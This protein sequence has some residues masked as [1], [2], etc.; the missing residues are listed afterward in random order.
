M[1]VKL[2]FERDAVQAENRFGSTEKSKATGFGVESMVYE[3]LKC[4]ESFA[5][6]DH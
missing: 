1:L 3:L 4:K 5:V 6:Y 2:S